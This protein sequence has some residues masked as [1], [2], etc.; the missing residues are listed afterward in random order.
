M[1][2]CQAC[3]QIHAQGSC[4]FKINGVEYCSLCNVAHYGFA[5]N[6]P[7]INS[8][9]QVRDMLAS[10]KDSPEAGHL[11][12]EALRYLTGLKGTLVQ[13]KK[14]KIERT[15]ALAAAAS[16]I[17]QQQNGGN[18]SHHGGDSPPLAA[19]PSAY[20]A[21]TTPSGGAHDI[22]GQGSSGG[23]YLHRVSRLFKG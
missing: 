1:A 16:G 18:S 12:K 14:H 10:L 7:H 23:S 13:K 8:E 15:Q 20:P 6:C 17:G 4:Q 2:Q 9:T 19:L 11:K 22:H 21:Y 5:R 3:Q